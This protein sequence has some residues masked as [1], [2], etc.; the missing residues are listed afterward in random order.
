M[1]TLVRNI[2]AYQYD[3]LEVDAKEKAQQSYLEKDHL[4]EFF[5]EDLENEL[6]ERFGLNNLQTCYSLTDCQ[7][8]GLYLYG[9]INYPELFDNEKFRKIALKG[10]HHRQIQSV[11]DKLQ[12]I[13]F[14]H[15]SRYSY[16]GTV[17]IEWQEC[18]LSDKKE[19]IINK[20]IGNV[21][22]WYFSFCDK[23]EKKGYD[24]FYNIS[25]SNMREICNEEKCFFTQDG[26]LID[27]NEYKEVTA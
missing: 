27:T 4:P 9:K 3:E 1:K 21:K 19:A 18:E 5:S 10:I 25:E 24:Y 17:S 6:R 11:N 13:V 20:I 12:E 16:A 8:D 2:T 7:G 26:Y 23:W 22:S 15:R 14:I